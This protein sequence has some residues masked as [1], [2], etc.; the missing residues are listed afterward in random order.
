MRVIRRW[1]ELLKP[2]GCLLLIEGFW[3][4][5]CGLH[6]AE[7]VEAFPPSVTNIVVRD[8]TTQSAYW[9]KVVVDERYAIIAY[10]RP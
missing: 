4:T 5:D 10:L 1:V 2:R 8:L 9:G 6:A 7:I 3:N